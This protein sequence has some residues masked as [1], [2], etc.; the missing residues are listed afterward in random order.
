MAKI[1]IL[2]RDYKTAL[3]N[4]KSIS[5]GKITEKEFWM[6]NAFL[7]SEEYN[8]AI[9]AAQN[10]I[11]ETEDTDKTEN[12][13]LI[14]AESY[15]EQKIYSRALSTL[16][17]LRTSKY[18]SNHIPLVHYKIGFCNEMM[19]NYEEALRSYK[20][21]K[22][23]FPYHQ[24]TYAAEDRMLKITGNNSI[25]QNEILPYKKP[26]EKETKKAKGEYD[27]Y[28]QIGA[29]G[30]SANAENLGKR[31]MALGFNFSIIPKNKNGKKLF[32][33]AVGP[34]EGEQ[35]K[36]AII[37]LKENGLESFVLKR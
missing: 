27:V 24:Y 20:K 19:G 32:I 11:Y 36:S 35:F 3:K 1:D 33:V 30:N 16:E 26:P 10:F 2:K 37:K 31:V 15:L 17:T 23:D 4:L 14:I 21:L 18:I 7:K 5:D 22:V 8:K 25:N 34:F 12:A 29:F 13:F 28:L 6:A 9:I